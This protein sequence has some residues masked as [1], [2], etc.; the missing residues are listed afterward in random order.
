MRLSS[1]LLLLA[2]GAIAAAAAPAYP[3]YKQCDPRWGNDTMVTT[4]ICSVGCLMSS[5]AMALAG[6]GIGI[7][8]A[9]ADPGSLNAW[10]R[11]HNGY[12]A[13]NDFDEDALPPLDPSHIG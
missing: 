4:T 5:T 7:G 9:Q 3:L 1:A 6:H 12:D 8:G 13:T 11:T 10:L 2:G